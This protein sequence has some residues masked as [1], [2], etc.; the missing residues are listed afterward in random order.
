MQLPRVAEGRHPMGHLQGSECGTESKG[1]HLL[2][3]LHEEGWS[4]KEGVNSEGLGSVIQTGQ[5]WELCENDSIRLELLSLGHCNGGVSLPISNWNN[6]EQLTLVPCH[7]LGNTCM[8]WNSPVQF[9]VV[10]C[11]ALQG[12]QSGR[13]KLRFL[14]HRFEA[15]RMGAGTWTRKTNSSCWLLGYSL[16]ISSEY[17]TF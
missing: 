7:V 4:Y 1:W 8:N 14:P 3:A 6:I 5:T 9:P 11:T 17:V 16:S 15:L 10:F 13:R 2:Y 12:K